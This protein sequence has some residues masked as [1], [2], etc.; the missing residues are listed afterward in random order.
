MFSFISG[1]IKIIKT[2]HI[3][4]ENKNIGL[5]FSV[6]LSINIIKNLK[7]GDNCEFLTENRIKNSEQII[8]F[9]FH[10]EFQKIVFNHI[11]SISGISDK[12]ALDISGFF[13]PKDL[14][15]YYKQEKINLD[16]KISGLGQKTWEKILF[17]LSRNKNLYKICME[18]L[19]NNTISDFDNSSGNN[20]E[21]NIFEAVEALLS[22]GISKDLAINLVNS[23]IKK[24]IKTLEDIIKDALNNYK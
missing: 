9:G 23:A 4:I 19:S 13:S 14:L 5:G 7:I 12:I 6:F 15:D 22:L 2:D 10:N 21:P 8:F 3:V 11:S 24:N 18:F 1:I 17:Y 16:I 20:N